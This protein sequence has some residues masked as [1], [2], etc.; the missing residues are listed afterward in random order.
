ME[1]KVTGAEF[2]LTQSI[3]PSW[4]SIG[5]KLGVD[6]E[7]LDTINTINNTNEKRLCQVWTMWFNYNAG[8]EKYPLSWE[9]LRKLL[10]DSGQK[11]IAKDFFE[12]LSKIYCS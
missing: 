5:L 2:N 9:G 12:F 4:R 6:K 7:T 10:A 1:D 8:R 11:V 3:S